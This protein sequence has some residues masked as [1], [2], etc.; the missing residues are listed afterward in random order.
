MEGGRGP[1]TRRQCLA[2]MAAAMLAPILTR[3]ESERAVLLLAISVET[4]AGANISDARAAYRVWL[5]EIARQYG[6]RTAD[7][8]PDI[9]IPSD[10]IIRDIRQNT[11]DG[12]G[13]TALELAKV[14]DLTDPDSLVLQ[15]HL[16]NGM[17]YVLIVHDRSK[18]R[19]VADL[20]GATLVSHLHRDMILERP[21]LATML[22]ESNLEAPESFF[23]SRKLSGSLTQVV[24]PVF[25]HRADVACLA[26][27]SWETA[28]DLNPQLG[29]DLRIL[30]ASP[31]V[32]PIAFAFRRNTKPHLRKALVDSIQH[33]STMVAG[34][35]IVA[36]YQSST[37]LLR[38]ISIMKSTFEMLRKYDR[39]SAPHA[40]L[41]TARQ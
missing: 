16:A 15:E 9:F 36:L 3:G 31:K 32:I 41:G 7:T 18:F 1:I 30:A 35:Q 24:L 27:P 12:Y 37:F 6:T 20:R 21:W 34:Q 8:V 5:Q 23:G 40:S 28:L 13:V 29:R 25:F 2:A 10:E 26:R 38:P 4:L 17:E 14:A 11:I 22:A 33:I 19:S 39:V